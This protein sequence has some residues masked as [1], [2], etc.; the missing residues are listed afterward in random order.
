M[1]KLVLALVGLVLA[2]AA[3]TAVYIAS[4]D[5]NQHKN[6]IAEQFFEATGRN[7]VFEGPVA[8]KI[9]PHP[10]LNASKVKIYNAK[11]REAPLVEIPNLVANLALGPLLKGNV[12]VERMTLENPQINVE[13]GDDGQFNWEN[14]FTPEQ[15]QTIEQS[16]IKFNSISLNKAQVTFN[17][18]TRDI[19]FQ[20]DDLNGEFM[21]ESMFGPFHVEGN[22]IKD[23]SPEG[24]A[25]SVGKLSDSFPTTFNLVITHPNSQ[26]YVRFDGN[27]MLTNQ[28]LNGNLI[29]ESKQLQ[30]FVKANFKK[31][32]LAKEYDY[33]LALTLDMALDGDEM[34]LS[35]MVIKYGDTQGAG[36]MQ[37]PLNDGLIK[38]ENSIRPRINMAFN[39]TELN[40]DPI[41]FTINDFIK[42]YADGKK[43]YQP[44]GRFDW[45]VDVKSLKTQYNGQPVKN[46]EASF[47]MI[48]DMLTINNMAAVLPGDTDVKIKGSLSAVDDEPFYNIE[49]SFN[50]SDFLKTLNWLN[51]K[52][53]VS[54]ASTYRKAVG[55]ARLAGTLNKIQISPFSLTM[56]KSSLS[57]EAGI[58]LGER[59]DVMLV[60][61]A[62]MINFDNYIVPLP[63][64]EA[65]KNWAQRMQYRFAR[66][67]KLNDFDM[68]LTAHLDLGI[69]EALPFEKVDA[70]LNLLGGKMDI[71]QLNI[72]SVANAQ[73][74]YA[75][76]LSGFGGVPAYENLK[77]QIKTEDVA[78]LINKFEFKAPDLDYKQLKN[79]ETQGVVTGDLEKF[80]I[81][82][83]S[84]LENLEV[85]Y[86]GQVAK[87]K[88]N[89]V[90][91][92][93]MEIKHP[94]FVKLL[95]NLNI[96]YNPEAFSLGL[97][98][99]KTHFQ[100]Q[101]NAFKATNL[102]G[103]IG[104]NEFN[105]N[106]DFDNTGKRPQIITDMEINKLEIERFLSAAKNNG[107]GAVLVSPQNDEAEFLARPLFNKDK[108]DFAAWQKFDLSGKVKVD[109]LSY[110]NYEFGKSSM[111][112][113]LNNGDGS[114]N[115]IK[116]QFRGGD[117]DGEL[118]LNAR[119]N[120]LS[121]I[122]SLVKG[123]IN[124][125]NLGGS[126]Y[127]LYN[128]TVNANLTFNT[129]AASRDE[130]ASNFKGNM[131][132]DLN[133]VNVKGWDLAAIYND[134]TKREVPD[135]LMT[136]VKNNLERGNTEFSRIS[137]KM[138][139][140]DGEF[141]LSD[142]TMQNRSGNIEVFGD[143]NIPNWNM[144]VVYNV[145]Y[146]EP[147]YLP[148]Y[149]FSLKGSMNA[150]LLDVNV[151]AL[152]DL[153]KAKQDKVIADE[154]AKAAAERERLQDLL[155]E[156]LKITQA[157]SDDISNNVQPL[158]TSRK[159]ELQRKTAIDS[160]EQA[161]KQLSG[162]TT[163]L[164]QKLL[165]ASQSEPNE[166]LIQNL[167]AANEK[168]TAKLEQ[169]R[170]DM[171]KA[172]AADLQYKMKNI[173]TKLVDNY[174]QG[175]MLIFNF[176]SAVDGYNS[177][178][179]K[180]K[181]DFNLKEDV[182]VAGWKQFIDDKAQLLDNQNQELMDK[183]KE[184]RKSSDIQ[185]MSDYNKELL[186]LQTAI[187]SDLDAMEDSIK[188][189]KTYTDEKVSEAEQQ[190]ADE[191]RNAEV[192]RKVEENTGHINIKKT[193]RHITVK[194]DIE[195][196]EKSEKL[197]SEEN[198][199]LLDFS[200]NSVRKAKP[201]TQPQNGVNVIKKGR[202]N[203][204]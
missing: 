52:P 79:F 78:A 121:G 157:L 15:R 48:N 44:N 179:A 130:I 74:N 24:F 129:K 193:G 131:S 94:D 37:I 154:Q 137:G 10:Y 169:I 83:N 127:S 64:E 167:T 103:N 20:L 77:Y 114:L 189:Y 147:Q 36:S 117:L 143:G 65:D 160:F 192:R 156:Q 159:A 34:A 199:P 4:I 99:L 31:W 122:M 125:M 92:G 166:E 200:T 164:A 107:N 66:L 201:D 132:F 80:A 202:L 182:N 112:V 32:Q 133:D 163:D 9:L 204:K 153:Y 158:M 12:E 21:A 22:Y 108:F 25:L 150:P 197:T 57:G 5:W 61:N 144:N 155:N 113:S 82:T 54:V 180:I 40:L 171:D 6:K 175:K 184:L 81:N 101:A 56:D 161:E 128:G 181:T 116:A 105:G 38:D 46:F 146:N 173:Y 96:P 16:Q 120:V 59:P 70:K 72:N 109:D 14:D 71:E 142:T 93:D 165:T 69:Y 135:G 30:D 177:R 23:N 41:V 98:N 8:F 198:V 51:I 91:N 123:E 88:E 124:A 26:S 13:V 118:H 33:P 67:G 104:F 139:F 97:L 45:I 110:K 111:E 89:F 168:A 28:I 60:L 148:G 162:E 85:N 188:Q 42:T 95:N 100:G 68:Q 178:L 151:S 63:K 149:S 183:Y 152:F 49:T 73:M 145:K 136:T 134:I 185:K 55:N 170:S 141:S 17:D 27:F 174:N 19:A 50:S 18:P 47:D 194:R 186:E 115:N 140:N 39:F 203:R 11:N 43:A 138:S 196:I 119:E 176:N 53:V 187:Q 84:K 29:V 86:S 76:K 2:A 58:K 191:V 126:K 3:G 1:K 75:G 106:I 7:I 190:Y 195:D 62:D 172:Y 102:K 90:Y 35:N 87:E